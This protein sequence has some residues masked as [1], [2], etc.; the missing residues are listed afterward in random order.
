MMMD[1]I[2]TM[3]DS[4]QEPKREVL[5]G[6]T[7]SFGCCAIVPPGLAADWLKDYGTYDNVP[8]AVL[9]EYVLDNALDIVRDSGG[10]TD[11]EIDDLG[12]YEALK[13][14]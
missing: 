1:G 6:V 8:D 14:G 10:E 9:R 12:E 2:P 11:V 7:I 3:S 5:L 4:A 13:N